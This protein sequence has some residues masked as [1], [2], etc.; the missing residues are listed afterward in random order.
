[1]KADSDYFER[2]QSKL[3]GHL[4]IER[5]V[6]RVRIFNWRSIIQEHGTVLFG[7]RTTSDL[8]K[9]LVEAYF[10]FVNHQCRRFARLLRWRFF[11]YQF[12]AVRCCCVSAVWQRIVPFLSP[13][14]LKVAEKSETEANTDE[15][16][17]T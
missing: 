10:Y 15:R 7:G 6:C 11:L 9:R 4:A 1:M 3:V 5:D 13:N 17:H 14:E 2:W 16:Y 8:W 12:S